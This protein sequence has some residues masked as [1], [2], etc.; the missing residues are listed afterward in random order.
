M[1][2]KV[3]AAY[4]S[5]CLLWGSTWMFI[6]LGL[7]DLPPLL[8]AGTRMLL[9]AAV[10]FPFAARSGLRGHGRRALGWMAFVGVLQ[11]GIPYALLFAGQQWVPSAFAAV[12][13]ATFPVWLA[14]VARLLL[15]DQLLTPRKIAA[16][17][18]GIAGVVLLQLPGLAGHAVSP[19]AIAGAGLVLTASVVVAF[20]NVLVRRELGGSPAIVIAFVQVF[21]GALLLLLLSLG[22]ERGRPASFTPLAILAVTYL[23]VLGTAVTYLFLF[24]LIPRVPMSA[25]GAIPLLDTMVAVVLA[26]IV[27]REP[28]GW[29]L[30]AGGA[31]VLTGAALANQVPA[32]PAPE[33]G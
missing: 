18:L 11:I 19:L 14:L 9:A 8:F 29:P 15:P 25:I 17:L 22:L 2:A 4:L 6:K 1:N 20:A 10:L 28:L 21:T 7:R 16:A 23:A 5:C 24:W 12:L 30:L 31:L 32:G 13:F 3:R 27:L 33:A 26:A